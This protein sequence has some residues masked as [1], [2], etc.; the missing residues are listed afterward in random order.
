M[1][2][3]EHQEGQVLRARDEAVAL[4]W[5]REHQLQHHVVR[6]QD[7]RR[8][9][10][11]RVT[12]GTALLPGVSGKCHGGPIRAQELLQLAPLAV[13]QRVHRVHDDGADPTAGAVPQ[14]PI[15]DRHDIGHRLTR[16]RAGGQDIR[17][18]AAAELD[19]LDLMAVEHYFAAGRVID[20]S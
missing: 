15:D 17:L 3:V 2:L 16:P 7:V 4:A 14:H 9:G 12:L 11:D 10:Q 19:G 18:V 8:P 13:R 1:Q 20:R 5:A 6:Q